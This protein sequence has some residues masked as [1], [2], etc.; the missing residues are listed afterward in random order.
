[1]L[2]ITNTLTHK[3]ELFQPYT[4]DVVK[5]YVCGITPYDVAHL[6][7]GRCY[8]SFDVLYRLLQFLGYTVSYCRN[9]TD[10]DDKLLRKAEESFGDKLR[11]G[12]IASTYIDAFHQDMRQ[13]NCLQPTYEPRVTEMIPHIITFITSLIEKGYAYQVGNSVYFHVSA[14]D[15][16]GALS[17]HNL[18]DLC[19][20]TRVTINEDKKNLLDFALWKGE[21][22]GEFWQSPWGWGRPGWHIE[23]S[24]MAREFLGDIID[25]HGGGLDL[26]FP[27]HEN[28]R[29][30]SEA[31]LNHIF[32]RYWMHN[33][34]V[35]INK[36]K[37]S[38]SLGNFFALSELFQAFD[39]MVLRYY[40]LT[41]HYR[42][43]LDFAL[44]D[45]KAAEKSYR[46]LIRAFAACDTSTSG[47]TYHEIP[48]AKAMIEMLCNDLNT[49][50]MF[51]VLFESLSSVTK[52]NE[53][54]MIRHIL[55]EILGLT[56]QE[57]PEPAVEITPEIQVLIDERNSARAQKDWAR[58]DALR[59]QLLE[60]GVVLEDK[61]IK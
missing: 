9:F 31:L 7:H 32:V 54:C 50:G 21:S 47:Y 5:L 28:E 17:K 6:G 22:E 14:F 1:M 56:L 61:K 37:M 23:C 29:A 52:R 18:D 34:F 48:V 13:L 30:Q 12:E 60:L 2:Y 19:P 59:D 57:L 36:E 24:V 8:I 40:L 33:G 35:Q 3:K 51:G 55:V 4:A 39:P 25:I 49:P 15:S 42:A 58:A 26:V 41:H 38:K 11:Y 46:K 43:P 27:H 53:L 16:Y 45:V 20:G 44:D 10:I